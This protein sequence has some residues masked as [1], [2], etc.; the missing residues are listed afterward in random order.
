[1]K[2]PSSDTTAHPVMPRETE[3]KR[4]SPARSRRT[5]F[6][7]RAVGALV[8]AGPKIA[9]IGP[10]RRSLVGRWE[11]QTRESS[12]ADVKSGKKPPGVVRDRTA[13]SVA[14]LKVVERVLAENRLSR[15]GLRRFLNVLVGDAVINQGEIGARQRFFDQYGVKPPE[16]L[17]I[18]PTKNCNLS[19][20]GCY[21]D[22]ST[23]REKLEWDIM[24]RMIQEV[25]DLWG[26]RF[27]VLSGGEPLIYRDNGKDILDLTEKH[28]DCFFMMYTN[29]TLIDDK[30]AKRMGEFG[31]IM[32]AVSVEG[33]RQRTDERRGSGIFD[34][35]IAAME[36]LRREKVF[37]GISMTA[38]K[39]N[40]EEILSDEVIDFYFNRMGALFAWI[41][42]YMPIGRSYTLDLLPTPQQRYWMW[43]RS[44]ELVFE[45]KL[46]LA[47]FWNS[48]SATHGCISAGREGGYMAVDWNGNVIPC[49]FLPYS[50]V[51]IHEAYAQGKN[52]V[53]VWAHPFFEQIRSWQRHYGYR[54]G[55]QGWDG[56]WIMPCP[57]RDHYAEFYE[58]I[59]GYDIVPID[60]N[61]AA[62]LQDADYRKGLVDYNRAVAEI[63]DPIWKSQYIEGKEGP[64]RTLSAAGKK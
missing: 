29:A 16:I 30:I 64:R 21:A 20:K 11:Q 59:K 15:A 12:W 32:P 55:R 28:G 2:N 44:W 43:K 1:M 51:N 47:D 57:I 22:S 3:A 38:T 31:N 17:L 41:F 34:R 24:D 6:A 39:D 8:W 61:A 42:Q 26:G 45:R 25:H 48:G 60:D 18:S 63:F 33:L 5:A 49:V 62:A 50:P 37:F 58:M 4:K 40:V 56:N 19:C 10:L 9:K 46:F 53:D 23:T 52:L 35:T 7:R 27:L 54:E 14:I 13:M 36:R